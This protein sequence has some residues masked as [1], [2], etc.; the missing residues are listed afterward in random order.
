MMKLRK[1][2]AMKK[3]NLIQFHDFKQKQRKKY[4]DKNKKAIHQFTRLFIEAHFDFDLMQVAQTYQRRRYEE[5]SLAWDMVDFRE[6]IAEGFE[7]EFGQELREALKKE[8]WF[9]SQFI[10][11]DE[12]MERCVSEWILPAKEKE[13]FVGSF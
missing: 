3:S 9:N 11:A 1:E 5:N 6:A 2:G 8:R 7:I 4:L 12:I 13:A 10:S